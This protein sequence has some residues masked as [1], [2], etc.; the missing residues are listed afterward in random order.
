MAGVLADGTRGLCV[1]FVLPQVRLER[2]DRM[3]TLQLKG[4]EVRDFDLWEMMMFSIT[5]LIEK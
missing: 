2:L 4:A 1:G 3:S 5:F